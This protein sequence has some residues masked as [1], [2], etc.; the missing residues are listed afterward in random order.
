MSWLFRSVQ[1]NDADSSSSSSS[2]FW[3]IYRV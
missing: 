2:S 3:L 1:S